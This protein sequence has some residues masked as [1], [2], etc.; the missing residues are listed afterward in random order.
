MGVLFGSH[1]LEL[2][3]GATRLALETL[4]DFLFHGGE[5]GQDCLWTKSQGDGFKEAGAPGE[6]EG[7]DGEIGFLQALFE[8]CGVALFNSGHAPVNFGDV[9]VFLNLGEGAV[10][11]GSV[12]FI[13][14]AAEEGGACGWI[15]WHLIWKIIKRN[16]SRDILFLLVGCVLR[17]IV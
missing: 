7:R 8:G 16:N 14:Q 10:E 11:V 5:A 17:T 9:G 12:A 6:L 13:C 3:V 1:L 4:G 2:R 15:F